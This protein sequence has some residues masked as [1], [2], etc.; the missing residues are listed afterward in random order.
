MKQAFFLLGFLAI[1]LLSFSQTKRI[2]HRSHS[3]KDNSFVITDSPDNFGLPVPDS[4]KKKWT[5][6]DTLKL[7]PAKDSTKVKDSLKPAPVK[8]KLKVKEVASRDQLYELVSA[9][10]LVCTR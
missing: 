10:M 7:L 9:V 6:K 1:S 4:M 8:E 2:A 3:G 5:A